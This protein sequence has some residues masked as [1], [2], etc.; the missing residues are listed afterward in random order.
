MRKRTMF[1]IVVVLCLAF[2]GIASASSY[3]SNNGGRLGKSQGRGQ[4]GLTG[5]SSSSPSPADFTVYEPF[6]TAGDAFCSATNGCGTI[7]SGGG[8][9]YQW[10]AGDFVNS[11]TFYDTGISSL[12]DLNLN[13]TASDLLAG[14]QQE[15]WNIYANGVFTGWYAY[16]NCS[17]SGFCSG[18][19]TISGTINFSDIAPV[20]GGYWLSIVESNTIPQGAGSISW[21]DGGVTGL[22]QATPEPTSLML[23]GSGLL[24]LGGVIRRRLG[25]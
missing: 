10:T 20:G 7:P 1:A 9:F 23:F 13:W 5:H 22:S 12:T 11:S 3:S 15:N 24:G 4:A 17:G 25:K 21:L 18:N 8:T 2:S 16:V 19:V 14:G 6:P